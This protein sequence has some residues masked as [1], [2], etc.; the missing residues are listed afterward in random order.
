M[1][2]EQGFVS[3]FTTIMVSLLLLIVTMSMITLET[4]QLRKSEDSEQSLRAYYAAEAGIEDGVNKVS[5]GLRTDTPCTASV[6]YDNPGAAGWTCQ[7]I[8][9]TGQPVGRLSQADAAKTVD[10][11]PTTPNYHSVI[12]EWNQSTDTSAAA[13]QPG[14]YPTGNFPQMS[15]YT[16]AAPPIELAIAQYPNGGIAASDPNVK[17]QNA[18]IV[19]DGPSGIGTVDY[20]S[21]QNHGPWSGKCQP[22]LVW[23]DAVSTRGGYNCYAVITNIG[24]ANMNY[25]FR[26]RSRYMASAFRMTFMTG[27]NGN[28]S[29]VPVPDGMATI[30]VT[31]QAGKSYRRVV[32]KLPL[33]D[34]AAMG[35][36]YV[37][38]SDTDICKNFTIV[39][40][41]ASA[42]CPY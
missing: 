8:T 15:N 42:G 9:F 26:I 24:A 1:R 6:N 35:L 4:V 17:L 10:P 19:P 18:V 29:V 27:A 12:V 37:M 16:Y 28:G 25:L 40:G 21:L 34:G 20:G 38:F 11:G 2:R 7:S 39:G 31:A 23:T 32:S 36:N 5:H 3:L 30:D 22:S 41:L 33:T 13:Y 14:I